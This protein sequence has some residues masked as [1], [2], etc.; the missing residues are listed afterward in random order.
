MTSITPSQL[1]QVND[2]LSNSREFY[3]DKEFFEMFTNEI[4]ID[5][6]TASKILTYRKEFHTNPFFELGIADL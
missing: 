6:K 3:S 4:G 5:E 1:F 2:L